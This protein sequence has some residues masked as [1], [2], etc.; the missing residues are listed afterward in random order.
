MLYHP[1]TDIKTAH[2][3]GI[4]PGSNTLG[5]AVME[6]DVR[7]LLPVCIQAWTYVG[8]RLAYS[9]AIASQH[10][11]RIARIRALGEQLSTL[12]WNCEPV[13]VACESPFINV[14]RPQAY[15]ALVEVVAAI[16]DGCIAYD[17]VMRFDLIDPP[18][19]KTGVG[20]KGN[21]DKDGVKHAVVTHPELGLMTDYSAMDE[22]SIDAVAV[23]YT[24]L[25]HL[26]LY[27]VQYLLY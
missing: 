1:Q 20:A 5:C 13:M 18:S 27:G 19:V 17:P 2:L 14:R 6:F 16:R 24:G 26:R 8:E 12:Y 25:Q 11:Q 22:H 23:A 10:G 21:A 4:D 7:T 9:Q 3:I 15:G